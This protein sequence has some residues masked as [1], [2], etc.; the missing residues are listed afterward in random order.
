MSKKRTRDDAEASRASKRSRDDLMYP[1]AFASLRRAIYNVASHPTWASCMLLYDACWGVLYRLENY[2]TGQIP[3]G[4]SS[5]V[6]DAYVQAMAAMELKTSWTGF[7]NG[8]RQVLKVLR[9]GFKLKGLQLEEEVMRNSVTRAFI[10]RRRSRCAALNLPPELAS[11]VAA[12]LKYR[13]E[14]LNDELKNAVR[15]CGTIS[16]I[17]RGQALGGLVC[18][19]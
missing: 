11:L 14:E 6:T 13:V 10:A 19:L 4:V 12:H 2:P 3:V 15:G 5:Q 18:P 9:F 1:T 8:Q 17:H 16:P 7:W